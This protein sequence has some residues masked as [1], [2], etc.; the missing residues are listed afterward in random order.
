ML[1]MLE[2]TQPAAARCA[3]PYLD[4]LLAAVARVDDLIVRVLDEN[5]RTM[6]AVTS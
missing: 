6:Q 3:D 1:N 4:A 5:E 2:E